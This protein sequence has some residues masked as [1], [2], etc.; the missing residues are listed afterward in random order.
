MP[1]I[2]KMTDKDV[3]AV[4]CYA[5]ADLKLTHAAELARCDYR[6]L[7]LRLDST[8]R[9]TKLDPKNFR[10]LCELVRMIEETQ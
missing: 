6:T 3:Q 1:D 7:S 8:Y 5:N 4:L 9:K 2:N 10:D